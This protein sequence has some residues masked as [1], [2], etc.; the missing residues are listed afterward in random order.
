MKKI[1]SIIAAL[2]T[3]LVLAGCGNTPA[4]NFD[5]L[6]LTR[7]ATDRL[8]FFTLESIEEASDIVVVG[9]FVNDP[10]Q[11]VEYISLPG[12]DH[13]VVDDAITT[14]TMKIS[15]VMKGNVSVDDEIKVSMRYGIVDGELLTSSSLTP[16]QKGDEWVFFLRKQ[17]DADVYWHRGDSDGRYPTK[18]SSE[19]K[20]M[21]LS[22]A[23]ELGVY[24]ETDFNE[25]IYNELVEKYNV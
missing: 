4:N 23:P 5:G 8:R 22:D 12:F 1:V 17:S 15:R 7:T 9:T 14:C 18:K 24:N 2:A 13:E 11:R 16:M 20:I 21:P 25:K 10:V 3:C 19:N 6:K